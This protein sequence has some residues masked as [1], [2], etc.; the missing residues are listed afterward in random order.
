MLFYNDECDLVEEDQYDLFTST[1][2]RQ[3][4]SGSSFTRPGL[5]LTQP[6]SEGSQSRKRRS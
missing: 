5:R 4:H 2:I 1:I 3:R 6:G